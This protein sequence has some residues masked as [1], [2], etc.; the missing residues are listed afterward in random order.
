MI[1]NSANTSLNCGPATRVCR[2]ETWNGSMEFSLTCCQLHGEWISDGTI[3]SSGI[4]MTSSMGNSGFDSGG[5]RYANTSP[6]YST[7]GYAPWQYL[8]LCGL[9][10]GSPGVSRIVPSFANIQPG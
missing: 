7:V 10:G 9:P 6:L 1:G 2:N 4:S 3:R 8:C 5:P